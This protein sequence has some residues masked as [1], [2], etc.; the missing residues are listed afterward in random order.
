MRGEEG[1]EFRLPARFSSSKA[2]FSSD[3]ATHFGEG[4]IMYESRSRV[5]PNESPHSLSCCLGS[6][7]GFEGRKT[8]AGNCMLPMNTL[9]RNFKM[10][11]CLGARRDAASTVTVLHLGGSFSDIETKEAS[12]VQ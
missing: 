3:K 4:R 9:T 11:E 12:G 1:V 10:A 2:D 6:A 8:M 5:M 7:G